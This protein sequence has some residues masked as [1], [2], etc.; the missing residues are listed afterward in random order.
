MP[1]TQTQLHEQNRQKMKKLNCS[2]S[3]NNF[4][5]VCKKN[6]TIVLITVLFSEVLLFTHI[7]IYNDG[8]DKGVESYKVDI[9]KEQ[10]SK[11]VARM[12]LTDVVVL[13]LK[14]N[15]YWI[16]PAVI[17]SFI[18]SWVLHGVRFNVIG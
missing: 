18:I 10:Y 6:I 2:K 11:L 13:V 15:I 14:I 9:Q 12:S 1:N 5:L 3:M 16:I 17:V 4:I 8:F 7:L